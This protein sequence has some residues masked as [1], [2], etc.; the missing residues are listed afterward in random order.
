[1]AQDTPFSHLRSTHTHRDAWP[2][3]PVAEPTSL[4]PQQERPKGSRGSQQ[5]AGRPGKGKVCVRRGR[6][7]RPGLQGRSAPAPFPGRPPPPP[8]GVSVCGR[9]NQ[10]AAGSAPAASPSLAPPPRALHALARAC[11]EAGR[12]GEGAREG[13]V[14]RPCVRLRQRARRRERAREKKVALA[15]AARLPG[16]M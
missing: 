7:E 1:M 10:K 4:A 13:R 15:G 16:V 9:P 3:T 11:A 6:G 12:R 14:V 2:P 8:R 5:S